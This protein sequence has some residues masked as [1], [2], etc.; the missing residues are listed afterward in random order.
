MVVKVI[1]ALAEVGEEPG[2][3]DSGVLVQSQRVPHM[4]LQATT[5]AR[6]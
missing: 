3:A 1:G 6:V 4:S 2:E 5:L